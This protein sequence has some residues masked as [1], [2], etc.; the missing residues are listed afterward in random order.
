MRRLRIVLRRFR[1]R[2]PLTMWERRLVW[3]FCIVSDQMVAYYRRKALEGKM[4]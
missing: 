3:K 1:V 4:P 2:D